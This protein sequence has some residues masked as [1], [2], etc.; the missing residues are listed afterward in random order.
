M[1]GLACPLVGADAP[2]LVADL[3]DT[4]RQ[5]RGDWD[6][7]VFSGI[8]PDGVL[9]DS[10]CERFGRHYRIAIGPTAARHVASLEGGVDGFLGRRSKNFR[11][12]LARA[13]RRALAAG[14]TFVEADPGEDA[15]ALYRRIQAI[16]RRSW[17]GQAGVGI[18]AGGMRDFY[19]LMLRRLMARGGHRVLFGRIGERDVAYVLGGLWGDGYRGLQF[20]FDDDYAE[21]SLG[22]V[23]QLEQIR[24]LASEGVRTYDLGTS[25]LDYKA[26]WAETEVGTV[27]VLILRALL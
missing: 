12:A 20:S 2:G 16:E 24:R 25:G 22:N 7:L 8:P 21:L 15:D 1:W 10:L 17:K 4:C 6:V 3:L 9:F 19:R 18:E 14:L 13:E 11:R 27:A 5:S 23:C 26:R